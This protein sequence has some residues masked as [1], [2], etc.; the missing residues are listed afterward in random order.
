MIERTT[1]SGL[2]RLMK[3]GLDVQMRRKVHRE[4]RGSHCS[5]IVMGLRAALG[6]GDVC[7]DLGANVGETTV[8]LAETGATVHAFEPDPDNFAK[9]AAACAGFSNVV[10]HEAAAGAEAGQLTLYRST[11]LE[12]NARK[13]STGSTL[14]ADNTV[15]NAEDTVD[16]KVVD[17]TAFVDDFIAK[18]GRVAL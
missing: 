4:M 9:L 13:G 11:L 17:A 18:H 16:V 12:K 7:I 5:G 10:L 6:P 14:I 3:S 8:P 1:K 15:A 2:K